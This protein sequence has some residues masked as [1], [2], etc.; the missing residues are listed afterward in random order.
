M[1]LSKHF[2]FLANTVALCS[3]PL[4]ATAGIKVTTLHSFN[5]RDG[6]RPEGAL[7]QAPSGQFYGTTLLGGIYEYGTLFRIGPDGSFSRLA[8]FSITNG[9]EPF[10]G[11]VRG[12]N[13]YFYGTTTLGGTNLDGPAMGTIFQA[14]RSGKLTPLVAFAGTNGASPYAA[15]IQGADGNFY[16]TTY[17]GGASN[18]GTVFKMTPDGSITTLAAFSGPDGAHPQQNPLIQ[19]EDGSLYG[20]ASTGGTDSA[21]YWGGFGTVFK[22]TPDGSL[23]TLHYFDG[24]NGGSPAAFIQGKDG[25]FYGATY[26][27][28][29]SNWGTVF[30]LTPS[31][32]FTVLHS[33]TGNSDGGFATPAMTVDNDGNIYGATVF[34][35]KFHTYDGYGTIFQINSNSEFTT[36]YLFGTLTNKYNRP[37]DGFQPAGLTTARDGTIYGTA[38]F[39]GAYDNIGNGGH[40]T[41]FR[42]RRV[43]PV[44]AIS[45]QRGGYD[46]VYSQVP[47]TISG[48]ARGIPA[49]TNV[50]LTVNKGPSVGATSTNAFRTWSASIT[51]VPGTCTIRVWAVDSSGDHS[52]TNQLSIFCSSTGLRTQ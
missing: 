21:P 27:G 48:S 8:S 41:V 23:T 31:G 47:I 20:I 44:A 12:T 30:Q 14:T 13:G 43:R 25:N 24:T 11:L 39:G 34:G 22:L 6:Y 1:N 4:L 42:L 29:V 18:L 45:Q 15:L 51:P 3:L 26:Y 19:S 35:G 32:E 17:L 40:G 10:S 2:L 37:L 52:R 50:F 16:G 36:I 33:F 5:D 38:A 9:G 28:G 7:I 46:A 49:V